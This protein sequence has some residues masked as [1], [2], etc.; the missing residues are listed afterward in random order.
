MAGANSLMAARRSSQASVTIL[1]GPD[2]PEAGFVGRDPFARVVSGTS[3]SNI[4]IDALPKMPFAVESWAPGVTETFR[5]AEIRLR[6]QWCRLIL[7]LTGVMAAC[8]PGLNRARPLID[9][10]TGATFGLR[11]RCSLQMGIQ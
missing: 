2:F 6:L 8:S 11:G 4:V 1:I 7:V 9:Q 5:F 10:A 3:S